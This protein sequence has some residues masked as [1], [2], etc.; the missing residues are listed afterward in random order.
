MRKSPGDKGE[1]LHSTLAAKQDTEA[2]QQVLLGCPAGIPGG[3]AH[4]AQDPSPQLAPAPSGA[5]PT[6]GQPDTG[7]H[8]E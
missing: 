2:V 8:L 6:L 5:F 4:R 7:Q 1:E 3:S